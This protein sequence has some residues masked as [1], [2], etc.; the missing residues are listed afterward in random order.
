MDVGQIKRKL[1]ELYPA[2]D[3]RTHHRV[4]PE[5]VVDV[6]ARGLALAGSGRGDEALS[7]ARWLQQSPV[8]REGAFE[9]ASLAENRARILVQ[10]GAAEEA[11]DEISRL[12]AKPS[13]VS[14]QTLRLDPLWDPI[15]EDPRFQALLAKYASRDVQ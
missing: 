8:Y 10:A 6:A 14:V 9:G 13:W 15:R 11:L 4:S 12:L 2:L 7:E 5:A 1:V 3:Q